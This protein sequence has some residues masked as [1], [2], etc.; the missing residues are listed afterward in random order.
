MTMTPQELKDQKETLELINSELAAS[1]TTV[2]F[3]REGGLEDGLSG[4][5]GGHRRPVVVSQPVQLVLGTPDDRQRTQYRKC[6]VTA[7]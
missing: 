2:G 3:G 5:L 6:V 7:R 1:G 4:G